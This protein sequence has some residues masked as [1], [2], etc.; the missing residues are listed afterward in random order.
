MEVK[1]PKM[2]RPSKYK[3]EYCD[4]MI[5]FFNKPLFQQVNGEKLPSF[6]PTFEKFAVQIKV[7]RDTLSEW[8]VVHPEF[9]AAYATCKD[10]QKDHIQQFGLLGLYNPG[11]AKFVAINCTDMKDKIE[12]EN[13]NKN[14]SIN[15]D[16]EDE[17][18]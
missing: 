2:G 5:N 18:A 3:P 4:E 7:A 1:K 15:I 14:I 13:T 11:F 8:K 17:E 9:S 12:Q 16:G 10:L 6:F